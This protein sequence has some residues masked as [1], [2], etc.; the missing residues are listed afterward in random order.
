MDGLITCKACTKEISKKAE[1]C[2]GCGQPNEWLHPDL[3]AFMQAA[4]SLVLGAPVNFVARHCTLRG[5]TP[6]AASDLA[7][8]GAL[9]LVLLSVPASILGAPWWT[10]LVLGVFAALLLV[11]ARRQSAFE[12]DAETRQWQS[13]DDY[14]FIPVRAQLRL[15]DLDAGDPQPQADQRQP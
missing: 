13:N 10:P 15:I 9:C 6:S 4:P 11:N 14:L 2:P 12:F 8:G 5:A 1:A 3:Q 7:K